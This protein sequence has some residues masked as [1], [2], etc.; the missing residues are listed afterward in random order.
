MKT[1]E[2]ILKIVSAA[3]R[4]KSMDYQLW[5]YTKFWS[6]FDDRIQQQIYS[7]CNFEQ[8]EL[9]IIAVF[10]D[11]TTWTLFSS[12]SIYY[13]SHNMKDKISIECIKNIEFGDFKG[14]LKPIEFMKIELKN[15]VVHQAVYETG[16]PSMGSIYAVQTL[17]QVLDTN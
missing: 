17:Q 5:Q 12:R 14:Y 15:D 16:K 2:D 1:D 13:A 3:I 4:R 11:E 9:P 10:I 7:E 6:D 8:K